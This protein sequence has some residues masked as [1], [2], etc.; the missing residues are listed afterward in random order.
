MSKHY[1]TNQTIQDSD[2]TL[3]HMCTKQLTSMK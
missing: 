2:V 1:V 3:K